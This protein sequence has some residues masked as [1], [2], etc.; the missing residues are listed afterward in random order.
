MHDQ[1][2]PTTTVDRHHIV[3]RALRL[4]AEPVPDGPVALDAFRILY[5]D[6]IPVNGE[7]T[8]LRVLVDRARMLQAAITPI[9]HDV[10]ATIVTPGRRAFAFTISGR[11]TGPLSSPL[12]DIAATHRDVVVTGLDI[13]DLDEDAG[14]ITAIWA[15]ADWLGLL[16]QT[17]TL[18]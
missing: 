12:G 14:R 6:P 10:K 2:L 18:A 17:G 16:V 9:H 11:H 1:Q 13:F 3:E 5:V 7:P 8:D 4:W 15:V